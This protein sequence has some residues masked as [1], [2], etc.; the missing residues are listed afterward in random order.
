[1]TRPA[2]GPAQVVAVAAGLVLTIIGAI[3]LA[4][5]GTNFSD[6]AATDRRV[7]GL[8][9]SS[10]SALLQVI[11]GVILLGSGVF[12]EAARTAFALFGVLL[13]GW[14]IV[15]IADRAPLF[16]VWGYTSATGVL[17]IIIGGISS[18]GAAASPGFSTGRR[19]VCG[20]PQGEYQ[21]DG[22]Y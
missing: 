5:T 21:S 10:L 13:I 1:V 3:A 9:F 17:Y 14:G 6:L 12:P 11:A 7:E 16:N 4:R 18:V 15:V 8:G 2:F 19:R 20:V 22:N